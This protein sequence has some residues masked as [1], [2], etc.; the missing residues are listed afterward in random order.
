[1]SHSKWGTIRNNS[2]LYMRSF[3]TP[4]LN[5]HKSFITFIDDYSRYAYVYLISEKS[6]A[7]DKFKIF[8]AEVEN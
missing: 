6:N 3:P 1:M 8:K 4:S 5:G 2:H 7:L